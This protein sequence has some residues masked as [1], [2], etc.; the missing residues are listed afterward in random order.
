MGHSCPY[1]CTPTTILGVPGNGG[2]DIRRRN[3]HP[4]LMPHS[5]SSIQSG[6]L[7]SHAGLSTFDPRPL[8]EGY[9]PTRPLQGSEPPPPPPPPHPQSTIFRPPI[10]E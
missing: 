4:D 1:P 7:C 5:L 9:A 8:Q 6:V 2:H 3:G 10:S